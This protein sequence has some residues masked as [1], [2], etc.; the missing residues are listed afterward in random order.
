MTIT[1]TKTKIAIALIILALVAALAASTAWH[2]L[3][4]ETKQTAQYQVAHEEKAAAKVDKQEIIIKHVMAY[5]KK[6]IVKKLDIPEPIKSDPKQEVI[7]NAEVKA[8]ERDTSVITTIDTETGEAKIFTKEKPS[9]LF[10][11]QLKAEYGVYA[12]AST[13]G[14]MGFVYAKILPAKIKGAEIGIMGMTGIIG[15]KA[16]ASA[17]GGIQR[18]HDWLK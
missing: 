7:A 10:E 5:D 17:L 1:L 9:K 15:D 3:K 6:E 2:Y 12:G 11:I 13:S 4:P 14:A 8:S 18:R 16:F